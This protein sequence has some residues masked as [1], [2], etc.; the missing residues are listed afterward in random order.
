M[1]KSLI[2]GLCCFF[3]ALSLSAFLKE[4]DPFKQLLEKLKSFS[5][6]YAYEKVHLHLDKPYYAVGDDIWFKAYVTDSR[7]NGLSTISQILYV[8]LINEKDSIQQQLKLPMGSGLTWGDFKLTDTLTEGNYRIRAYTQWMRNAGEQYFFDKTVKIGNKWANKVFVKS[9]YQYPSS[10]NASSFTGTF[11]FTDSLGNPYNNHEV[12]YQLFLANKPANKAKAR[13]DDKG[14]ISIPVSASSPEQLINGRIEATLTLMNKQKVTKIL[15]LK[16]APQTDIYFFPESGRLIKELPSRVGIKVVHKDGKGVSATGAIIDQNGQELIQFS[17]N[18]LGMGTFY[19]TPSGAYKAKVR[20]KDGVERIIDLPEVENSGK[21]MNINHV[22]STKLSVKVFS[23]SDLLTD[24]NYL[25]LVHQHGNVF[26][27]AEIPSSKPLTSL[28]VAKDDLPSGVITFTLFNPRLDPVAERIVFNQHHADKIALNISPLKAVYGRRQA[29]D[30]AFSARLLDTAAVQGSF[31]VAVTN[32]SVI[33]PDEENESHIYSSLL[34]KSEIKGYIERPN[35]YFT[36]DLRSKEADL[37]ILM[38]T[39]GWRQIAWK[40]L[41]NASLPEPV[42]Q[43]ETALK[44][45]GLVTTS[46][47]KPAVKGRVSLL[48][49]EGGLFAIDTLTDDSGRFTF[50]KMVFGDSAKFVI[51][52]RTEKNKKEVKILMDPSIAPPPSENLN[53][54]D[55]DLN[56]NEELKDYLNKS[57]AYFDELTKKGVLSRTIQLKSVEIRAKKNPSPHSRNLNGPGQADA[58]FTSDDLEFAFSV[59]QFLMGRIAGV[60]IRNGQAYSSRS[61]GPMTIVLD[62]MVMEDFLLD[63][64]VVYDIESIEVL[65]SMGNTAVYGSTGVNGVLVI[66][67]KR[68][69]NSGSYYTYAP[70]II[71]YSPRGYSNSRTFYSPDYQE[72]PSADTDLRTTVYWNPQVI[73]DEKGNG[74]FRYF[75]TDQPG[76]YRVVIEGVDLFGN[77]ARKVFQYRVE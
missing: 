43:P 27:A 46:N 33:A 26:V 36:G 12:A 5:E 74:S 38:L 14:E 13:T 41:N 22:D 19:L 32:A 57:Q 68:G 51:Q 72:K 56:V 9:T 48:S 18:A 8:E 4:D 69:N 31:S 3:C 60:T 55:A 40:T 64:L 77:I 16:P 71:T 29:V 42:F 21:V 25:L 62:G 61:N 63:D 37:D 15:P 49:S 54:G 65:R 66:T 70:G 67:T 44:I 28:N 1:K 30:V 52:G 6:K 35:Y 58:I 17:T 45:S 47:N 2:L 75:N 50:D 76:L 11:V 53:H 39:Q 24:Q 7:T 73:S 59:S 34:L 23:S 20:L 10:G